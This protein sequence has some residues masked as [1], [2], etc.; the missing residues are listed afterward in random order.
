MSFNHGL[1]RLL[2]VPTAI[3]AGS[4]A[5]IEERFFWYSMTGAS[6]ALTI[7]RQA[8]QQI[9]VLIHRYLGLA[10]AG[11]FLIA[12]ITGS[13]IVF[14]KP[15]DDFLNPALSR[16][17][18]ADVRVPVDDIINTARNAV[19][20]QQA[21]FVFFHPADNAALEVWFRGSRL[22][23]YL[24]PYTGELL[25]IRDANSSLM[26]FLTDLHIHLLSGKTGQ[27]VMGWAGI[28]MLFLAISGLWIWW[29]KKNRWK[30]AF[31]IK[32]G[33]APV[34]VWLDAHKLAGAVTFALLLMTA[35]TGAA[36]ALHEIVTEPLLIALTGEGSRKPVPKTAPAEGKA[37]AIAGMMAHATALFPDGRITR[38]VLPAKPGAAVAIRMQL[39]GEIHQS[40]RTFVWF[41]QHNGALLR[42]DNA[43]QANRATKIQSWLFPLHT[44]VYGGL[45][46]RWLQVLTGLSLLLMTLTGTWVWWKRYRARANG[47]KQPRLYRMP[48]AFDK[49][50]YP[51]R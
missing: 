49:K 36:L 28:G 20:D 29:P 6:I 35:G 22:R 5:H 24:D 10:L 7:R 44:G 2:T 4:L 38:I 45:A 51:D 31:S 47:P 18:T 33:A 19:P 23:A 25:G 9:V 41:D 8:M 17:R 26:G 42:V 15:I 43:M 14:K 32:W 21:S 48:E 27:Q 37:A 46:T 12:G 30:Q 11:L 50:P 13:A 16:V 34:R 39:E 1:H 3:A 40:G